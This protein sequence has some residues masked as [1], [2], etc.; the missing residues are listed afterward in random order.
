[1]TNETFYDEGKKLVGYKYLDTDFVKSD[2]DCSIRNKGFSCDHYNNY[3]CFDCE[4]EQ[5]RMEYPKVRY[6][7]DCEWVI[8]K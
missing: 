5:V 8:P 6:T 2:K 4:Q 1:M 3:C 7:D